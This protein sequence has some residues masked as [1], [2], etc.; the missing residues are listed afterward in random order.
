M[1]YLIVLVLLLASCDNEK[2]FAIRYAQGY[3]D[4][5]NACE[6]NHKSN[7]FELW[8][9]TGVYNKYTNIDDARK[10]LKDCSGKELLELETHN[11]VEQYLYMCNKYEIL[12]RTNQ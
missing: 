2:V 8:K 7:S 9:G 6:E 10:E 3:L 11:E 5:N 12:R 4:G 1:K